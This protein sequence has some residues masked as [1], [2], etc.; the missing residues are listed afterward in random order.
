MSREF[1]DAYISTEL[2]NS[3]SQLGG[4]IRLQ[5]VK[6]DID[7][8]QLTLKSGEGNV[9]SYREAKRL[10]QMLLTFLKARGIE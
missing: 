1:L 3:D 5:T 2:F 6:V 4:P 8:I 10:A 7:G 9:M